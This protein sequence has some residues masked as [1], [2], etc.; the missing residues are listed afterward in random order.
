MN[1]TC[2]IWTD[3][4]EKTLESSLDCKKIQP[5]NPKGSKSWIFIWRTN[6]E[7]PI[8]WS[9]DMK[10]WL[11]GKD[12]CWERLKAGGEGK[13]RGWDDWMSSL[14]QWTWVWVNFKSWWWTGRPGML[15]F[16]G[17]Q[18]VRHDWMT[19]LNWT[20]LKFSTPL[21]KYQRPQL[22]KSFPGGIRGKESACQCRRHGFHLWVGKIPWRRAWQ[23]ILV[24]L[25]GESHGQ[26]SLAGTVHRI[27]KS[28]IQMKWLSTHNC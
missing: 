8:L 27:T 6:A 2:I 4:L 15:Q 11:T 9:P 14:T 13:D 24:F 26:R 20:E 5:V 25:P 16:M 1:Y 10:N 18:R 12:W 7:A 19:E 21:D 17:L 28:R 3:V 22:L 23:P